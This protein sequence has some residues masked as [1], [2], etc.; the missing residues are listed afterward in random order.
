MNFRRKSSKNYILRSTND[1]IL[2]GIRKN[3]QSSESNLLLYLFVRRAIKLAVDIIEEHHCY[4][5]HAKYF[6][7]LLSMLT[8]Y[9]DYIRAGGDGSSCQVLIR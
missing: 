7:I 1:L 8:P 6:N 3:C 9:V 2:F 4:Q 5:L